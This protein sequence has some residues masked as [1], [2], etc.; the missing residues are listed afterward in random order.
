MRTPASI[1]ALQRKR[2]PTLTGFIGPGRKRHAL[3]GGRVSACNTPVGDAFINHT[4]AFRP[5]DVT[6]ARCRTMI[7]RVKCGTTPAHLEAIIG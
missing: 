5:D 7:E 4:Q 3:F 6:C 1:D 2:T